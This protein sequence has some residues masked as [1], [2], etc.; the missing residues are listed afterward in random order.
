MLK[1]SFILCYY[2]HVY[3][4]DFI[5][6]PKHQ[7]FK[8]NSTMIKPLIRSHKDYI[9]SYIIIIII[10]YITLFQLSSK[11]KTLKE[12]CTFLP[13][14]QYN[15]I[16]FTRYTNQICIMLKWMKRKWVILKN[17][18]KPPLINIYHCNLDW[19]SETAE[20]QSSYVD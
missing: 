20:Q 11:L 8:L 6:K 4:E 17:V 10:T 3:S 19:K 2:E 18:T 16:F 1:F 5:S 14:L 13:G 15:I 9:D 7:S 12:A